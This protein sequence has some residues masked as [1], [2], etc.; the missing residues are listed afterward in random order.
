MRHLIVIVL[1]CL[2]SLFSWAQSCHQVFELEADKNIFL[3][4]KTPYNQAAK[5]IIPTLFSNLQFRMQH[6]QQRDYDPFVAAKLRQHILVTR[7][8]LEFFAPAFKSQEQNDP[9]L[10]SWKSLKKGYSLIG[11]YRS[12]SKKEESKKQGLMN[13][14][15]TWVEST[16]P[17]LTSLQQN[18]LATHSDGIY[19][20]QLPSKIQWEE[21]TLTPSPYRSAQDIFRQMAVESVVH[22]QSNLSALIKTENLDSPQ[23]REFFHDFRKELRAAYKVAQ[24]LDPSTFKQ[25]TFIAKMLYDMGKINDRLEKIEK[26]QSNPLAKTEKVI[27]RQQKIDL[28]WQEFL[29][30]YQQQAVTK[31]LHQFIES[32]QS[33][34]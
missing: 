11:K 18:L 12:H 24:I 23:T 21:S 34:D 9:W 13:Q 32:L 15:R 19:P 14:I 5:K 22:A 28:L 7:L 26:M 25:N 20:R 4:L 16:A 1:V 6:L 3:N 17:Q 27:S 31:A 29:D 30:R 8:Y 10:I 33:L 2:H